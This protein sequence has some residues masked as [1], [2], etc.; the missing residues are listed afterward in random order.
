MTAAESTLKDQWRY[1]LLSPGSIADKYN[2][3][4]VFIEISYD[5]R[6]NPARPLSLSITG[7]V[8]PTANG[9]ARGSCGQ[10]VDSLSEI[11]DYAPGWNAEMVA[12][13]QELWETWHL[14]TMQAGTPAQT[15]WVKAHEGE[16]PG[17]PDS[18]YVWAGEQLAA[19]GLNPDPNYLHNGAPYKYGSAWLEVSVPDEILDEL[20]S[21]P[22][23]PTSMPGEWNHH[24]RN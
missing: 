7:V 20:F 2:G 18:H 6:L 22:E 4:R 11:T 8:G 9:N 16:F 12:R 24:P 19:A 14:N 21:L 3:G 23:S 17:Y 1:R 15:A 5:N 10:C 13:L